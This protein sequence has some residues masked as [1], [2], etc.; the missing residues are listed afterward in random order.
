[1]LSGVLYRKM[2]FKR[3]SHYNDKLSDNEKEKSVSRHAQSLRSHLAEKSDDKNIGSEDD[4]L[5]DFD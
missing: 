4:F 5:D 1:M 2:T 3:R